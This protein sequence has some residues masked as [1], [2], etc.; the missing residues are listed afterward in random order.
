[1]NFIVGMVLGI[2]IGS[3][4]GYLIVKTN[5][6]KNSKHL[7]ELKGNLL[8]AEKNLTPEERLAEFNIKDVKEWNFYLDDTDKDY[9]VSE[10]IKDHN[11]VPYTNII[12]NKEFLYPIMRFPVRITKDCEMYY[13]DYKFDLHPFRLK[14]LLEHVDEGDYVL[15]LSSGPYRIKRKVTNSYTK[16]DKIDILPTIEIPLKAF[17]AKEKAS[18]KGKPKSKENVNITEE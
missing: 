4:V 6:V 14:T 11:V 13:Q 2:I 7:E 16:L 12:E 18:R 10:Y 8:K 1:M 5:N 9:L 15:K 17:S 3:I